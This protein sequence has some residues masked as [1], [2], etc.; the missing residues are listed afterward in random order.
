MHLAVSVPCDVQLNV[1][2]GSGY[3]QAQ[4]WPSYRL[5]GHLAVMR[6]VPVGAQAPP[7]LEPLKNE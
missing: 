2:G 3:S 5:W 6:N 4:L 1:S 7:E